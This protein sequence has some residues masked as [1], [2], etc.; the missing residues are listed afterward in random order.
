M[1]LGISLAIAKK[2]LKVLRRKKSIIYYIIILPLL[3]SVLF[4][5]Y[6]HNNAS[7]PI[8]TTFSLGIDL[9]F[10]VFVILAAILPG[11]IAAYSIVGEKVEKSL[12]PLLATPTTDGEILLGKSIAAFVPPILATWAGAS[13]FMATTDYVTHNW[14]SYYYFPNWSSGVMLLLLTPLAAIFSIELATIASSRVSDVRGANQ[15]GSL[16]F[17]P[18]MLVFVAGAYGVITLNIDNLLIMSGIVLII[19]VA[20]FYISTATFRREEILTKWK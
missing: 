19:D 4:S 16:M 2:E 7:G 5:V 13:I 14:L 6:V 11:S 20:L 17:I 18:F 12:E 10:F 1:N 15:I 8:P 3:L 9:L